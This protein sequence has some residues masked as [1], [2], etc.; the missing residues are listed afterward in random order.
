MA[1][2]PYGY[3]RAQPI[4]PNVF[5][6]GDQLAVVPSFTG[7]GIAIALRS[8]VAAARALL[9]G[10]SA[11]AHQHRMVEMLRPQLRI[12][13]VLGRLLE[14]PATSWMALSDLEIGDEYE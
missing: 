11:A 3:L 8:G 7:D 12:A 9:A 5:P 14:T 1:S 13:G 2:I 4:A 10:Q 6:L